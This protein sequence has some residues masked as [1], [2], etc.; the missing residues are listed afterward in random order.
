VVHSALVEKTI[1]VAAVAILAAGCGNN[2]TVMPHSASEQKAMSSYA[3]MTPQQKIDLI[4]KGPMPEAAKKA[5]IERLK[6][7]KP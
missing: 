5:M 4:E 2:E 3:S 1:L 6:A 7:Q